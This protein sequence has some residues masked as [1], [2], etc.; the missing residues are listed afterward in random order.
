MGHILANPLFSQ[1]RES[2][3][4]RL[5]I[6]TGCSKHVE[7]SKYLLLCKIEELLGFT[8]NCLKDTFWTA[9]LQSN[10]MLFYSNFNL[11]NAENVSVGTNSPQLLYYL[12]LTKLLRKKK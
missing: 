3:D 9:G 1:L 10:F 2:D 11:M 12:Q 6:T 5:V 4:E 8:G 7:V